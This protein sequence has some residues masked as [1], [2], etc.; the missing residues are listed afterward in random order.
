MD[1]PL[2]VRRFQCCR[3]LGGDIESLVY[4]D[5][6]WAM[7]SASVSPATSSKTG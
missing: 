1:D 4:G 2:L 6:P 3:N 7:R 5:G